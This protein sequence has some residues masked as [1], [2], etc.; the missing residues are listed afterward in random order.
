MSGAPR[1]DEIA[2]AIADAMELLDPI[3]IEASDDEVELLVVRD[4]RNP[5]DILIL[6]SAARFRVSVIREG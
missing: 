4:G 6:A 1:T 2:A 3:L 5:S